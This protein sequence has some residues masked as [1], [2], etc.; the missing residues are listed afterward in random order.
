MV[1]VMETVMAMLAAL[2]AMAR[3]RVQVPAVITVMPRITARAVW[4]ALVPVPISRGGPPVQAPALVGQTE[5][6]TE[7]ET[8]SIVPAV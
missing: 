7:T 5:I 3:G 4:W 6:E 2:A 8:G 1:L